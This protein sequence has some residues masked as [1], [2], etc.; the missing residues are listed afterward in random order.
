MANSWG[1]VRL[2]PD[3]MAQH[4]P[5][6]EHRFLDFGENLAIWVIFYGPEGGE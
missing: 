2:T 4:I 6:M 1:A 5:D 3:E